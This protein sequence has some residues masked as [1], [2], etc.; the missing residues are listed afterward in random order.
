MDDALKANHGEQSTAHSRASNQAE[1]NHPQQ[2]AGVRAARL[3]QEL[4]FLCSSHGVGRSGIGVKRKVVV[5]AASRSLRW[6]AI[7]GSRC[8]ECTANRRQ[9]SPTPPLS[10]R[11]GLVSSQLHGD[12]DQNYDMRYCVSR[13]R[14]FVILL[15]LRRDMSQKPELNS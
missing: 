7:H 13:Y 15:K 14:I 11:Q 6:R 3:L 4:T 5:A 1:D 2:T 12:Y 9:V 10:P 8:P